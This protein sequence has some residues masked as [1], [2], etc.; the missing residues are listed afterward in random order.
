EL[1][2]YLHMLEEAKKRDHRKLGKE[3]DLFSFHPEAPA[4]PF[5][6]PKGTV[7]YNR[8]V[9]L[10]RDLYGPYE[11][12]EVITP[13][14]LDVALWHRSGH[15]E[16][17]RENMFFTEVDERQYAVKPMNC[18]AATFIFASQKRSYR[19]LPL[20]LADF[21][22][23]HRYEKSGVTAGLTRVRTFCQD[24]A[25][26]F[27]SPEQIGTEVKGV[28]DMILRTYEIF[29]FTDIKIF[30]STRPE[31]RAGSDALW[32]QAETA[33][34]AVLD[35]IGRPYQVNPGDGAFYG[36]KIDFLVRDALKREHQLGT[37]QLDFNMPERFDL[38]YIT[39]DNA[40]QRPVMVHRAVLGSIERFMGILIEHV[41]GAFPF[42]LAPVQARL[43]PIK[44]NHGEYCRSFSEKLKDLGYRVELDDRNESMGFKTREAQ[45]AKI[46]F[47]LVAGDREMQANQ[48]AVRKYGERESKVM[49][50]DEVLALLKDLNDVPLRVK[51]QVAEQRREQTT[52]R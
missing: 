51:K 18:P 44:D 26:I 12:D 5:F 39:S 33:L 7:V 4:S 6:H 3:L 10:M 45:T 22:R 2:D 43:I 9:Q 13:Q 38:N 37:V 11:Y 32:D 8:L 16:N 28:I 50:Q 19:N 42:W 36:P 35:S 48:F 31:K 25:H 30:L 21:G 34:K 41:A 14:I 29:G 23:L 27:C 24:D 47:A 40:S 52:R 1:D 20:R 15:Y 17:Y 46:P 49:T